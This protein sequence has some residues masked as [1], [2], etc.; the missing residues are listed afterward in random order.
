MAHFAEIN[1][2]NLVLRVLV[3][4][5]EF[6]VKAQDYLAN[7]LGLGGT[8]IQTSY[9]SNIRGIYAGVGFSYNKTEDIFVVPQPYPSWTREGSLW[10]PPV[11]YPSDGGRYTWNEQNQSWDLNETLAE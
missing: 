10:N 1:A 7:Q 5:N 3:V 4:S 11:E 6:E 2:D 8:W 9:N